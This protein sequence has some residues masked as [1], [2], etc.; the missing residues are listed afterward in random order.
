[1]NESGY[2]SARGSPLRGARAHIFPIMGPFSLDFGSAE[3]YS[4]DLTTPDYDTRREF[5]RRSVRNVEMFCYRASPSATPQMRRNIGAEI[6]DI[7]QG[8]ARV[9][10][11]E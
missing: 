4:G 8:G 9:R 6:L 1:E 10:V 2:G 7:S 11:S 5:P 3:H